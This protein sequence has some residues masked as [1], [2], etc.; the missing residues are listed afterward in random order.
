MVTSKKRLRKE[1]RREKIIQ[2][3]I[4]VF[5]RYGLKGITTK[6]LAKACRISE[7]LLY[8][9]FP[10]KRQMY[11]EIQEISLKLADPVT[12]PIFKQLEPS[13]ENLVFGLWVVTRHML[14]QKMFST[15]L[16]NQSVTRAIMT[17][18]QEDGKFASNLIQKVHNHW[19]VKLMECLESACRNG[20]LPSSISAKK[21]F[22]V[23]I[24]HHLL[25]GI[26]MMNLVQLSAIDYEIE[27]EELIEEVFLFLLRG[28]GFSPEKI[29]FYYKPHYFFNRLNSMLD[30][31][32]NSH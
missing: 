23:W 3:I 13:T 30:S 22:W 21:N 19:Q 16:M 7:A 24:I 5:A 2:A 27:R 9:Y 12:I 28:L 6:S 1:V 26:Q 25:Y 11:R 18:I 14:Q 17:N 20:D 31:V 29:Q 32:K 15:P 10:S 8:K 4:P